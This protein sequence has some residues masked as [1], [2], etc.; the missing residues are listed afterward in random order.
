MNF[1]RLAKSACS[2]A[3]LGGKVRE[4]V[5]GCSELRMSMRASDK[6]TAR[7]IEDMIERDDG[8]LRVGDSGEE[9][10]SSR[11]FIQAQVHLCFAPEQ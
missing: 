11:P 2:L 8:S 6:S 9:K 1:W 4:G 5:G 3:G 7:W 10:A